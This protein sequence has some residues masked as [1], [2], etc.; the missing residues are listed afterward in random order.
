MNIRLFFALPLLIACGAVSAGSLSI[1]RDARVVG[2][3]NLDVGLGPCNNPAV[4]RSFLALQTFHFGGTLT[5][6]DNHPSS[7][8]GST[9]GVW[10]YQARTDRYAVHMQFPRFVDDVYD[11]L[12]D[13]YI[14]NIRLS[15]NGEEMTGDVVAYMRNVDESV[16]V[17][18]CGSIGGM[19]IHATE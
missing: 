3:W 2:S 13:I 6:T 8:R 7:G 17:Q 15:P 12:Q 18:A 9:E 5:G 19:R 4:R 16:R 11:G 14:T 10:T 1:P